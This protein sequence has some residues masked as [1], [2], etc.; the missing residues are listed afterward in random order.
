MKEEVGVTRLTEKLEGRRGSGR[1]EGRGR[2]EKG[3]KS[4]GRARMKL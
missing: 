1:R 3:E 2:E 4:A